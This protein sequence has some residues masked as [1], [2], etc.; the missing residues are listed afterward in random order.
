MIDRHGIRARADGVEKLAHARRAVLRLLHRKSDE[1]VIRRIHGLRT[2]GGQLARQP[3]RVDVEK[4]APA[5][6]W[7]PDAKAFLADEF[8]LGR[9]AHE[10]HR[11]PGEQQ[12]A[13]EQRAV[14][15]P[16][17]QDATGDP[18]RNTPPLPAIGRMACA[19]FESPLVTPW[20]LAP[21]GGSARCRGDGPGRQRKRR[22]KARQIAYA[23]V[24]P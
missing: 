1:I 15:G 6:D 2:A 9:Q 10:V 17:H 20:F 5:A 19:G 18:H 11:V 24:G 22:R 14:R 3:P 21:R 23:D 7:K 13:R 12:L 4:I 8:R 16:E